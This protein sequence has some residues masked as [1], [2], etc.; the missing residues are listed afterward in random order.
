[1]ISEPWDTFHF[2]FDYIEF[3]TRCALSGVVHSGQNIFK[4]NYIFQLF[5]RLASWFSG[6]TC[7]PTNAR[8]E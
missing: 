5:L 6:L 4:L 8:V 7:L 1:M 3:L 2:T